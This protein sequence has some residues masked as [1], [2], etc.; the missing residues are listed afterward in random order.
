MIR[1]ISKTHRIGQFK[2]TSCLIHYYQIE[3]QT[4]YN[5]IDNSLYKYIPIELFAFKICGS[6]P[7]EWVQEVKGS[8]VLAVNS[9]NG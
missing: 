1:F 8:G 4:A 3:R 9:H 7:D 2:K 6:S 5:S